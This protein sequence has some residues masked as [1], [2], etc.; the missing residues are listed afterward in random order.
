[1]EDKRNIEILRK[2]LHVHILQYGKESQEV[3]KTS[4]ELDKLIVN[5]MR[6]RVDRNRES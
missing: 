2:R 3:L 1:M 5:E 4:Q 6:R